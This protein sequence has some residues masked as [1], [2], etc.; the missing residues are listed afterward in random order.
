M[1]QLIPAHGITHQTCLSIAHLDPLSAVSS[2]KDLAECNGTGNVN[3]II[4]LF[5]KLLPTAATINKS[6]FNQRMAMMRDLGMCL[7]SLKRHGLEPVEAVPDAELVLLRIA[8]GTNM[9]P[10]DTL[11]HYSIWN[12]QGP[13]MRLYTGSDCEAEIVRSLQNSIPPLEMALYAF[14]KMYAMDIT[15]V[16]FS[17]LCEDVSEHLDALIRAIVSVYKK[18]PSSYFLNELRPYY[19]P[20]MVDGTSYSGPGAVE[21]PLFLVDHALWACDDSNAEYCEMKERGLPNVLP[22]W[23]E[24]YHRLKGMSSITSMAVKELGK[25]HYDRKTALIVRQ[26]VASLDKIYAKLISFRMPHLK[27][28]DNTYSDADPKFDKGRDGYGKSILVTILELMKDRREKLRRAS[29]QIKFGSAAC[30]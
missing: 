1:I 5:R 16:R 10:R 24:M 22:H 4:T 20:I 9:P 19:E 18:V 17:S 7:G 8:H 27:L 14:E 2:L 21:I 15:D 12:P 3:G 26:S 29:G 23:R 30:V 11:L 6:D 13:A 25:S 28:A